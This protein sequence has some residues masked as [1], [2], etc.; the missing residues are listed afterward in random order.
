MIYARLHLNDLEGAEK[1]VRKYIVDDTICSEDNDIVFVAAE[2]LYKLNGN[3]KAEKQI[4]KAIEK[5]EE[6]LKLYYMG[7]DDYEDY[8]FNLLDDE[9]PFN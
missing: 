6:E 1:L 5:Y 7:I 9:F 3:K 4:N 2:T 8:D